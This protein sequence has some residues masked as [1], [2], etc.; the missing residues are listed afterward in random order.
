M[1]PNHTGGQRLWLKETDM[2]LIRT[3]S[4][5]AGGLALAAAVE[6][7][8]S[9][10]AGCPNRGYGYGGLGHGAWQAP[11]VGGV[12]RQFYSKW[13]FNEGAG[14]YY[15]TFSFKPFAG[16]NGYSRAYCITYPTRFPGKTFFYDPD[17]R[18]YY[19][20]YDY[21]AKN[22]CYVKHGSRT[23]VISQIGADGFT[24][25]GPLPQFR[26]GVAFDAP[27]AIPAG[28]GGVPPVVN[29]GAAPDAGSILPNGGIPPGGVIPAP[30]AGPGPI[31]GNGV[32]PVPVQPD[33]IPV[34]PQGPA[35]GVPPVSGNIEMPLPDPFGV[36]DP[37]TL[38]SLK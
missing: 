19:G 12:G 28:N 21:A 35:N 17:A 30:N 27:P 37:Q 4:W 34:G 29:G 9:A 32:P 23:G 6:L 7:N 16:Y 13:Q 22:F 5:V 3:F 1:I 18:V 14:Y 15:C 10:Q 36:T 33:P 31:N 26:D 38:S 24:A 20:C 25:A 2:T 11:V 8:A